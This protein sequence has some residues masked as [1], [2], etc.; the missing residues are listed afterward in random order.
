MIHIESKYYKE[1][2][3]MYTS[4]LNQT[5]LPHIAKIAKAIHFYLSDK[6]KQHRFDLTKTQWVLLKFLHE[7][8]GQKQN[9]LALITD[10]NKT[11]LT[12]LIHT[13]ERKNLVTRVSDEQD[14]RINRI[15]LTKKGKGVYQDTLPVI[16][17]SLTKIQSGL[18][19]GEIGQLNGLLKKLYSSI[20]ILQHKEEKSMQIIDN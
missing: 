14:K 8:D 18:S 6:L 15:Y 9:D 1:I 13:M 19:E 4:D 5:I 11:S 17:N 10:R 3:Q 12:R 20:E 16:Y 7:E 2:I